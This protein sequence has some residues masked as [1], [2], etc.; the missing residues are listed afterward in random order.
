M[1][2]IPHSAHDVE[3]MLK[4]IGIQNVD[5]LFA[6]IPAEARFKGDLNLP[7]ALS[8]YELQTLLTEMA[9]TPATGMTSFL[10]AG[11]YNHFIPQSV[12]S[13][14]RRSEFYTAY[15]PYQPEIS[16]GTLQAV[17]EFQ[18]AIARIL[19]M[20]ISNASMY[21]G[22]TVLV[23]AALMARRVNRRHRIAVSAGIHP[24]YVATLR[25]YLTA[26]DGSDDALVMVPLNED[27]GQTDKSALT[28]T[29][30][31]SISC[32]LIGY[33]NFFGVVE[34]L[35]DVVALA[36]A[37]EI[38][39][40][41]S[42]LDV[43]AFGV[44][45]PPGEV[46]VDIA[47]AEGQS[48]AVAPSYGGPGLGLF[49]IADD[50]K[51][52]RQMPGRLVGRTEDTSGQTGYVLT[53]ATREQHIRREK[54]T[55]NICTNHGLCALSAVVNLCMLGKQGYRQVANSCLSLSEYL[56]SKI[57]ELDGFELRY[58]GPTFNEF[59]MRCKNSDAATVLSHLKSQNILGGV[60]LARFE[61]AA[62]CI[63]VAVTELHN[64]KKIDSFIGAL[65]QI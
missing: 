33:P 9:S 54:A 29:L 44:L 48:I 25:A 23:E 65:A 31:D 49:A 62:D 13:L 32:L 11:I 58:T 3:A 64:R 53:L 43:F 26:L 5:D 21:D 22:A 59:T 40:V 37:K 6:Q 55:S 30:D 35:D 2:Y 27:T 18:T 14:M 7:P 15:T 63:L 41:T 56:K 24:E 10:G 50:K 20:A 8:E 19:G 42:T 52:L 38:C 45:K 34:Q 39:V 17:F 51:L 12:D 36:R 60:D 57:R 28:A 47:T 16:Q 46:G 4:K 1:R 61:L